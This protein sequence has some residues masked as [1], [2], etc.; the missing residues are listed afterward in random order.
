MVIIHPL[1]LSPLNLLFSDET[2]ESLEKRVSEVIASDSQD[3]IPVP[4][5]VTYH[6]Y[7]N[8]FALVNESSGAPHIAVLSNHA[9]VGCGGDVYV[10]EC[11]GK[12]HA[13][14]ERV[15]G[16]EGECIDFVVLP[17]Q[18]EPGTRRRNALP[19]VVCTSND[20]QAYFKSVQ[21]IAI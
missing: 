12:G 21:N 6:D 10:L 5:S 14:I 13:R 3:N 18:Y 2:I 7:E 1:L 20:R 17:S 11:L 16:T 19:S 15:N 9:W 8:P 4:E